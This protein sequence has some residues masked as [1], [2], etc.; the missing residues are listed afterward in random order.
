MEFQRGG[1]VERCAQQKSSGENASPDH[2]SAG[3]NGLGVVP[4]FFSPYAFPMNM[5]MKAEPG[6]GEIFYSTQNGTRRD[7]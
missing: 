7:V 2:L 6:T 5:Q 4:L 1:D 3:E